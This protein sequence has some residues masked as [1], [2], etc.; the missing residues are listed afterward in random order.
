[1]VC[2]FDHT[3]VSNGDP[4][5]ISGRSKRESLPSKYAASCRADSARS[6]LP[7]PAGASAQ[8]IATIASS[9]SSMVSCPTGL[10]I[11][12]EGMVAPQVNVSRTLAQC[13]EVVDQCLRLG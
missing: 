11:D 3:R 8:L 7:L 4:A 13:G 1:M 6:G 12:R 10:G 9:S 2:I 5:G